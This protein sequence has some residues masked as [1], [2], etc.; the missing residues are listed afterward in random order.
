[1]VYENIQVEHGNLAIDRS[2]SS[3]YTMDH[4]SNVLI[5][6]N[7]S[8]AVIFTYQLDTD[9]GEVAALKF[10]GYYYWSLERQGTAGFRIRKWEI[11]TNDLVEL[12]TEFSYGADVVNTYDCH[13]FAVEYYKDTLSS[14]LLVGGTTFTVTDGSVIRIGDRLVIGPSTAVGFTGLYEKATV[15]N[16]VGNTITIS[17][18]SL[19]SFSPNEPIY[20]SRN[21]FVFSD[22][23]AAGLSGALYKFN[24]FSGLVQ[25]VDIN[26]LYNKVRG[27]VFFKNNVMFVRAGDVVW[28]NPASYSI[29]KFQAIDNLT[30][31]RG[32]YIECQDLAGFSDT[33]YRLEQKKIFFDTGINQFDTE[34]WSPQFNYITSSTV[35]EIYFVVLKADP[36][37]LPK[38]VA[39]IPAADL[40]SQI[41][42]EVFDQF[43]VPVFNRAVSL[44]ST[45]G[46]VSPASGTTDVN[47]VFRSVYT[48]NTTVGQ[49][50][51]TATVT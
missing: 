13:A 43:R 50:T 28:L 42:V 49:I 6:K 35:P 23:A 12:D 44:A 18:P 25:S 31:N 37:I 16:K 19:V 8:G 4:D 30:E 39:G 7:S 2:G 45:G 5:Q 27:A 17:S 32:E 15:I 26:N 22:T 48:A 1:M 20:F 24:A 40:K 3:F 46:G 34:D 14:A 47:G 11:G 9:V 29:T 36:P 51:V 21:F 10:D 38:S 41:T 33:L